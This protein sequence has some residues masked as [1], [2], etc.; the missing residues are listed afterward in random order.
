MLHERVCD[1]CCMLHGR[2]P[3]ALSDSVAALSAILNA[4]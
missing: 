3:C 4:V 1:A 2:W